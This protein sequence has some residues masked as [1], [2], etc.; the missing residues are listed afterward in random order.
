[1]RAQSPS[2]MWSSQ[3]P[4][5]AAA[6]RQLVGD[7]DAY[8]VYNPF[9]P[10]D[11]ELLDQLAACG[12]LYARASVGDDITPA[13][14]AAAVSDANVP[15]LA[16]G[17]LAWEHG[18]EHMARTLWQQAGVRGEALVATSRGEA[19]DVPADAPV[20]VRRDM[21]ALRADVAGLVELSTTERNPARTLYAA[22][23]ALVWTDGDAALAY[24]YLMQASERGFELACVTLFSLAPT[25]Q[26]DARVV[27]RVANCATPT[28]RALEAADRLLQ[29]GMRGLMV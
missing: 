14:F 6:A 8:D 3:T 11:D 1:M 16:R 5:Q 27:G 28:R 10:A 25:L 20:G 22:A 21:L 9:S 13:E 29:Q 17:S 18:R 24:E 15:V 7:T 26:D 23:M 12:D 4:E 19:V 2:N